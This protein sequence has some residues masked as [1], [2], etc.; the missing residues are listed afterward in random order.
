MSGPK[1]FMPLY[2]GDYLADTA[3]LTATEHGAYLLLI[4]HYWRAGSLPDDDA[5]LARIARCAPQEWAAIRDTVAEFFDAGWR[6][7]RIDAEISK[8]NEL[9]EKRALGARRANAQRTQS[10]RSPDAQRTQS[11][12]SP[13]AVRTQPQPQPHSSSNEEEKEDSCTKPKR[14][15]YPP[16]FEAFW[17]DYPTDPLMSKKK[18]FEA[19][20]RLP[21]EDRDAARAAIPAFREHCRKHPDYRP[22]HAERFISQRRFDGFNGARA[23]PI[24]PDL[25]RLREIEAA[26]RAGMVEA[27]DG[28]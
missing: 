21:D 22:V 3:H 17:R 11:G 4:M 13:D 20:K 24:D 28:D 10:G 27:R 25:A 23:S 7:P 14:A 16:E 6:H 5:K 2:I 12:R 19:W 9:Y 15:P 18:A 26:A 8:A 1:H